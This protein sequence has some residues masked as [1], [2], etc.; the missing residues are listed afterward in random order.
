[1]YVSQ[2]YAMPSHLW[3][4][5]LYGRWQNCNQ[6][7]FPK[8]PLVNKCQTLLLWLRIFGPP[9]EGAGTAGTALKH[10]VRSTLCS[11]HIDEKLWP[12]INM[13]DPD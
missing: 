1:M 9:S 4:S 12:E 5:T 2:K 7:T 3:M 10:L 11:G 6:T 8:G 13:K